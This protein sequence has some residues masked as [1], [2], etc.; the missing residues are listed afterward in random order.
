MGQ[1][2][3]VLGYPKSIRIPRLDGLSTRPPGFGASHLYLCSLIDILM[4]QSFRFYNKSVSKFQDK[5]YLE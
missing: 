3:V 2:S 1:N 4:H 5:R